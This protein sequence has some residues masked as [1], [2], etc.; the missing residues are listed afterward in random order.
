ML[1][2]CKHSNRHQ[3][4]HAVGD[5]SL[6]LMYMCMLHLVSMAQ[7][8][9]CALVSKEESVGDSDDATQPVAAEPQSK[10][11]PLNASGAILSSIACNKTDDLEPQEL[12]IRQSGGKQL[13]GH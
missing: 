11:P 6:V 12:C 7:H 2:A 4:S 1:A 8:W 9:S 10:P 3:L 5:V 13:I